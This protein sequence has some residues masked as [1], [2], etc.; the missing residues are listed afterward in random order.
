MTPRTILLV[1]DSPDDA[2]LAEAAFA[3]LGLDH[4]LAV[5]ADGETALEYL[6][7]D[8]AGGDRARSMPDLV[9]LDLKLP[10]IDGFEVLRRVRADARAGLLP[11]VV[12]TSSIEER[13][14]VACYRLG[15][16]SYIRKPI[17]FDEFVQVLG[18]LVRYWL[19]LNQPPPPEMQP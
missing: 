4:H 14:V 15:A 3:R 10:G 16:N 17:N 7:H 1:E 9:L 19:A 11:V 5:A 8:G 18:Q 6:L 12:L 13:D 2:A